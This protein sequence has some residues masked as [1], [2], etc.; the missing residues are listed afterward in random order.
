M[1]DLWE[2]VAIVLVSVYCLV[3]AWRDI[4][5]DI[6]AHKKTGRWFIVVLFFLLVT[7]SCAPDSLKDAKAY[8]IRVQA[9]QQVL[10]AEQTRAQQIELDAIAVQDAKRAQIIK[11]AG[12]ENAK[13]ASASIAYWGGLALTLSVVMVVLSIGA[14][15]SWAIVGSGKAIARAAIV[16]ANLIYLDKATGQFPLVLEYVGKGVYSL[17][18]PNAK[19]TLM[20]NSRNPADRMMIQASAAIRHVGVLS[21]AASRSQDPAGMAMIPP[22][23]IENVESA[24]MERDE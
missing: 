10:D 20:L 17:T 19:F 1:L 8:K 11:D 24:D 9:D 18:D 22:L 16:K 12:V 15:S 5:R 14:G 23:I 13:Q 3:M 2:I 6:E 4:K 7:T 21:S